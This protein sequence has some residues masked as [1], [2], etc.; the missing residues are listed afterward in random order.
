MAKKDKELQKF[1]YQTLKPVNKLLNRYTNKIPEVSKLKKEDRDWINGL[2][3]QI[4]ENLKKTDFQGFSELRKVQNKVFHSEVDFSEIELEKIWKK[5]FSKL[6]EIKYHLETVLFQETENKK[7]RFFR[8]FGPESCGSSVDRNQLIDAIEDACNADLTD[9][10]S[11]PENNFSQ[12]AKQILDETVGIND[13]QRYVTDHEGISVNIQN[14]LIEW[15]TNI[16][17][18]I[19]KENPFELEEQYIDSL[20]LQ[21]FL[22][23]DDSLAVFQRDYESVSDGTI[24]FYLYHQQLKNLEK[25]IPETQKVKKTT[26]FRQFVKTL[27]DNLVERKSIWY[28][29]YFNEKQNQFQTK[30]LKEL[31]SFKK[32]EYLLLPFAGST[33]FFKNSDFYSIN[34]YA[35]LLKKDKELIEIACIVENYTHAK[36]NYEK[37]LRS[38]TVIKTEYHAKPAFK[39]QITEVGTSHNISSILPSELA[40]LKNP[41]TK[42]IFE[43]K[44]AHNQLLSFKYETIIP[45]QK[46][47]LETG[48]SVEE[49]KQTQNPIIIC[50]DT[51]SLMTGTLESSAKAIIFALKNIAVKQ[52]RKCYCIYFSS[53]I[54]MVDLNDFSEF[55][56]LIRLSFK[57][58]ADDLLS[59]KY[60]LELLQKNNYKN[61]KVLF[62]SDFVLKDFDPDIIKKIEIEKQK[63]T[64]FYSLVIGNNKNKIDIFTH[65]WNYNTE[66]QNA[67]LHLVEYLEE[68]KK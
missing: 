27:K 26:L 56:K 52:K 61:A 6:P 16:E 36:Q 5:V 3:R 4:W 1:I 51:N 50:I 48:I 44:F 30:L 10:I 15:I 67:N 12:R 54:E 58:K 39:G 23:N 64:D 24:D 38:K 21:N 59:L 45:D 2:I 62:I 57:G 25:E 29:K 60:A 17:D 35:D 9:R 32:L 20:N 13:N 40:L 66:S 7:K 34:K 49:N 43:I 8:K 55:I 33:S 11:F 18:Q 53:K 63:K 47:S 28:L 68:F 19:S 31:Q 65:N 42:K 22:D 41:A 14:D 37:K 46:K